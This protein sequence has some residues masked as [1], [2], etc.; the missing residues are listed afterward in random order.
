M[1]QILYIL[2]KSLVGLYFLL[3]ILDVERYLLPTQ[4]QQIKISQSLHNNQVPNI[5]ITIQYPNRIPIQGNP[6]IPTTIPHQTKQ[7]IKNVI[8]LTKVHIHIS[9]IYISI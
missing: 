3:R 4:K 2:S 1:I 7:I 5:P 8:A 6:I 9:Y